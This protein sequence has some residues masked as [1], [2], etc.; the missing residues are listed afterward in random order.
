MTES[1]VMLQGIHQAAHPTI[2]VVAHDPKFLKVLDMSLKLE[3]DYEVISVTGGKSAVEMA[4]CVKPDLFIMDYHL[5]DLGARELSHR[6]HSIKE[7]EGIPIILLN[8]P[9]RSWSEHQGYN[10]IFLGMPFALAE[11]YSA[12]N[13]SL[14]HI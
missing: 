5:L 3:F 13:E 10:T 1:E 7:L 2:L 11:L 14:G 9:V 4:E 12:V 6:L 8:S